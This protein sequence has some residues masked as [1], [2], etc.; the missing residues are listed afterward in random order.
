MYQRLLE[1]LTTAVVTLD[2]ALR[3][4]WMN[5]AAEALLA[6]SNA[7]VRGS[8]LDSLAPVDVVTAKTL[9]QR[10]STELAAALAATVPSINFPRPSNTDGTDSV[11]PAVLRGQGPD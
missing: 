11:R 10:G 9:Q 8:R 1:H 4:C 3:V 5:P 6:V 2:G 7:R